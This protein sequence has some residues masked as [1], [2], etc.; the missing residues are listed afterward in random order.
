MTLQTRTFQ[1]S[2]APKVCLAT[3]RKS[4]FPST[5]FR[6]VRSCLKFTGWSLA[7]FWDIRNNVRHLSFCSSCFNSIQIRECIA[8]YPCPHARMLVTTKWETQRTL[9]FI[10]G[11]CGTEELFAFTHI[12]VM[13]I[14][15]RIHAR[16]WYQCAYKF[17]DRVYVTWVQ[18]LSG[19][20]A[21]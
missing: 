7:T 4:G 6:P 17:Q 16:C 12:I 11:D 9:T 21:W 13:I 5:L 8:A 14:R 18:Q 20:Q 1:C 19:K 3:N 10:L 15:K 2:G